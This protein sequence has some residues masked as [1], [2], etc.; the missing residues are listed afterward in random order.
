M[1]FLWKMSFRKCPLGYVARKFPQLPLISR[2][3]PEYDFSCCWLSGNLWA[4]ELLCILSANETP[5]NT[6][7]S[8]YEKI[9]KTREMKRDS[10]WENGL[11]YIQYSKKD[12]IL[13]SG[14]V[15]HFAKAIKII[16]KMTLH[17]G[18]IC[19]RGKTAKNTFNI[20]KNEWQKLAIF[21]VMAVVRQNRP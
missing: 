13:Q 9:L 4:T 19:F 12:A 2:H 15:A 18:K 6:K 20:L 16:Q 3:A 11:H 14:K 17:T 8:R 5:K 1:F 21:F 10:L 7:Y